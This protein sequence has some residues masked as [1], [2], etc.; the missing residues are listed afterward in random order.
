[1]RVRKPKNIFQKFLKIY[2]REMLHFILAIAL[3]GFDETQE[4]EFRELLRDDTV[5]RIFFTVHTPPEEI[6]LRFKLYSLSIPIQ[7]HYRLILLGE[8]Y[9]NKPFCWDLIKYLAGKFLFVLAVDLQK[10]AGKPGSIIHLRESRL[11]RDVL[12]DGTV[13]IEK[14]V[15]PWARIVQLVKGNRI[16]LHFYLLKDETPFEFNNFFDLQEINWMQFFRDRKLR[17]IAY[18]FKKGGLEYYIYGYKKDGTPLKGTPFPFALKEK[19]KPLISKQAKQHPLEKYRERGGVKRERKIKVENQEAEMAFFE[20]ILKYTKEKGYPPGYFKLAILNPLYEAYKKA[21]E[22]K[23]FESKSIYEEE[24]GGVPIIETVRSEFKSDFILVDEAIEDLL[25]KGTL[26]DEEDR[27][28][29]EHY[30]RKSDGEIAKIIFKALGK[31][32]TKQAVQQRRV[33]NIKPQVE[34]LK[35]LKEVMREDLEKKDRACPLIK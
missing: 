35:E 15:W 18:E 16:E 11:K 25:S 29:A 14:D 6:D 17:D 33:H 31:P 10:K 27:I 9:R 4:K 34:R 24:E 28:I 2:P 22:K 3:R 26:K 7:D 21:K 32:M 19:Y 5:F 12:E 20:S 23:D 30:E 8:R 1:M 13:R